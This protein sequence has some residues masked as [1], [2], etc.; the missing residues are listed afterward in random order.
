MKWRK[1]NDAVDTDFHA[2]H[3]LR[4]LLQ[5]QGHD[6]P[7]LAARTDSDTDALD[8][9]LEQADMDAKLFVS[10][11]LPLQPLFMQRVHESI[12]GKQPGEPVN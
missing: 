10:L 2:G 4:Q 12:F 3:F 7:W 11:G 8:L 6:V 5:E 9:L 1:M